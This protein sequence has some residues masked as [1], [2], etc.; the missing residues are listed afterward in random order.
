M[1][2]LKEEKD[3]KNIKQTRTKITAALLVVVLALSNTMFSIAQNIIQERKNAEPT[4]AVSKE[5]AAAGETAEVTIS[6]ANNPGIVS[7]K[8]NVNFDASA[9]N[10]ISVNDLGNL[11]A[12]VHSNQLINPYVLSWANDTVSEDITFNGDI[13]KLQFA[14]DKNIADG[15]IL[16]ITVTYDLENYDICNFAMEMVEF[17][18]ENGSVTIGKSSANPLED[19]EYE[20]SGNEI[21]ITGYVGESTKVIIGSTYCINGV[22]YTV[23]GIEESAFETNEDI[24]SVVIPETVK[25]IGDY[26]FYDCLSLTEVTIYSRDVEFGECSLGYYYISRREDGIVEGFTIK[27]YAGST[28]ETYA[29]SAEEITF[30]EITEE[31]PSDNE[32]T[33]KTTALNTESTEMTGVTVNGS[34]TY[35]KGNSVTVSANK[36]KGYQFLGWYLESSLGG[37]EGSALSIDYDYMFIAEED[38]SLVAVYKYMGTG[39]LR[40]YGA[41]FKVNNGVTQTIYNYTQDFTIGEKVTLT[42]TGENFAYW[43][44]ESNKI[45]SESKTYTFTIAGSVSFT[46][47]YKNSTEETAYVEFVSDY[48]QVMQAENYSSDSDIQI[49]GPVHKEGYKFISWNLTAEEIAA[50]IQAG[51]TYIKVTPIYEALSDTFTITVIYDGDD[52][53]PE[54][55]TE[56][57]GYQFKQ[58]VA[59]NISG[60]TFSHWS[61]SETGETVLSTERV[62]SMYINRDTTVYAIYVDEGTEIT[63]VSTMV[64]NSITAKLLDENTKSLVVLATRDILDGYQLIE[65]GI[66]YSANGAYGKEGAEDAMIIGASGVGKGISTAIS[67]RG[68]YAHTITLTETQLDIVVYARGYMI[69][70]N[71]DGEQIIIYGSILSGSYNGLKK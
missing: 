51:Q 65:H 67:Q 16:P 66:L 17:S 12:T 19:F 38:I 48:G 7:A 40:V 6:I 70:E 44:N 18:V 58:M 20:L 59:K 2:N 32:I 3:L 22:E 54:V 15:T 25:F 24:T 21:I 64:T 31:V 68:T 53:N 60:R 27:G 47:V 62:Y 33:V 13:V 63:K 39:R 29:E 28:A 10:L 52:E 55:I 56:Y 50:Q 34:G 9:M 36:K 26:A 41:G 5:I 37:F 4:I 45:V 42:A 43:L 46:A 61:D 71:I 23:S 69:L 35:E 1:R 14:I 57:S 30:V 11:G 49:P 8:L